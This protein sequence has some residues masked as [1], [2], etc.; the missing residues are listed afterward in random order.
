MHYIWYCFWYLIK[1][2]QHFKCKEKSFDDFMIQNLSQTCF[3]IY[4]KYPLGSLRIHTFFNAAEGEEVLEITSGA[5][6]IYS[7]YSSKYSNIPPSTRRQKY[8]SIF[9]VCCILTECK[10]T[11]KIYCLNL[12]IFL[13]EKIAKS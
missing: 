13:R 11:R 5:Y 6:L 10:K 8:N 2:S 3:E 1:E 7:C 12:T 9:S 4:S